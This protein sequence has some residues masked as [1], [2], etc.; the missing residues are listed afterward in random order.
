LTGQ[1]LD[2]FIRDSILFKIHQGSEF[3]ESEILNEIKNR[4][5]PTKKLPKNQKKKK[6]LKSY[7]NRGMIHDGNES[8]TIDV[9]FSIIGGSTNRSSA[10]AV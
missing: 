3:F 10:E 1:K 7:L 5:R 9:K 8:K 2:D 4:Y 6:R